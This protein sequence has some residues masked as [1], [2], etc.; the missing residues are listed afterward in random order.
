LRDSAANDQKLTRIF[1]SCFG[2][3]RFS[4]SCMNDNP[5]VL[6]LVA[7]AGSY[8]AWLWL[9]D[10]RAARAAHPRP[11]ALPG[12]VP[13]PMRACVVAAGGGLLLT[14]GETW[15]EIHLGLSDQQ[16]KMTVLFGLYSVLVAPIIEELVFR[17]FVVVEG[18][19]AAA[20]WAGALV[21]SALFTVLHPFLWE[22]SK[23]QPFHF[24]LTAKG[25][26]SSGAVF[27]SSLWFYTMRFA[28][29]LN[30]HQ[31][32]LPCFVAHGA[33]NLAVFAI[34]GAQGFVGGWW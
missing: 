10:F 30:P 34:K 5:L 31:S 19:G 4:L 9:D 32:L 6:L 18:R 20:K 26:F 1:T 11:H 12:A 2:P 29:R 33:K 21:A 3:P 23:E 25:W 22:W 13:A 28:S 7:V 27:V 16:S 8:V 14:A 24:T 17:G 15:G